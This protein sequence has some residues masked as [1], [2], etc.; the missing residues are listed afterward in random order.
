MTS[1]RLNKTSRNSFVNN[2]M[3]AWDKANVLKVKEPVSPRTEYQAVIAQMI[4]T[5]CRKLKK[6]LG[7]A[8]SVHLLKGNFRIYYLN[9]NGEDECLTLDKTAYPEFGEVALISSGCDFYVPALWVD[10]PVVN[11]QKDCP[12]EIKTILKKMPKYRKAHRAWSIT[13]KEHALKRKNYKTQIRELIEDVSSSKQLGDV[14][15]EG[16]E[17]LDS[18]TKPAS[19]ALAINI[20]DLNNQLK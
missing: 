1:V 4:L 9:V 5:E 7:N 13:A 15:K 8:Y 17:Y 14:W 18:Y 3:D 10:K 19:T 12:E 20:Q 2:V 11:L 16:L 6:T